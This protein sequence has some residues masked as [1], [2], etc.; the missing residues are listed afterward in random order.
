[1]TEVFFNGYGEWFVEDSKGDTYPHSN[2]FSYIEYDDYYQQFRKIDPTNESINGLFLL[3]KD[4]DIRCRKRIEKYHSPENELTE[5]SF[6]FVTKLLALPVDHPDFE[7]IKTP[8]PDLEYGRKYTFKII[9]K[10]IKSPSGV[11]YDPNRINPIIE[12]E[13]ALSSSISTKI[14]SNV[15]HPNKSDR[16]MVLNQAS[17]RFWADANPQDKDTWP[18]TKQI[19]EWLE[20]H[21]YTNSLAKRGSTIIRPDWAETGRRPD[22]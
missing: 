9:R 6:N 2:L 20:N 11:M 12:Q 13:E 18:D 7:R 10:L 3:T 1:M 19:V 21:Q 4:D 16:L 15:N 14:N 5:L 17:T 22:E 8:K